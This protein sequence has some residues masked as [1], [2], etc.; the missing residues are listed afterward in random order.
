MKFFT[1][2]RDPDATVRVWQATV[3]D[4]DAIG[5]KPWSFHVLAVTAQE[6]LVI[7]QDQADTVRE[8]DN[9]IVTEVKLVGPYGVYAAPTV[10]FDAKT[11]G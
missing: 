8:P 4:P 9:D 10:I 1:D 5:S 7:A 2:K 6:A 11:H 3:F